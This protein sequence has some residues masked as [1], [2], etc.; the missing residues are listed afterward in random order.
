MLDM[1]IDVLKG[2]VIMLK[3]PFYILIIVIGVFVLLVWINIV[4]MHSKGKRFKKGTHVKIKKQSILKRIFIDAPKQ[5]ALDLINNDP[6]AFKPRGCVIFT[7]P[8]GYGKTIGQI[9]YAM[10]M[11][12]EYP[13]VKC[14]SNLKYQYQDEKLSHWK[15]LTKYK[16]GK[17]GVIVIMDETQNWFSSNQSKNFP[18]EMLGVIT[19][20]RKNR[21]IILGSA[22]SFHLLAKSVR[23]QAT[24]VRECFTI[25][26]CITIIRRRRPILDAEGNV[27][28]WKF[29][30]M[31]FFVH[32]ETLRK[33]YD[34]YE[35]IDS[36]T[37]AGF[38]DKDYLIE[39]GI[40]KVNIDKK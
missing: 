21:R 36:L 12:I 17:K 24:E 26:N 2:F 16:N 23:S 7:G 6:E 32:N 39:N 11:Q 25:A 22:Q 20:N 13:L 1:F 34:T 19:Q 5:Y 40:V 27:A 8:Q 18:P 31:Y 15:Q 37:D 35:V 29:L 9:E 3:Y 28:E 4:I 38:Q 33:A 14:I 30:G 10:R